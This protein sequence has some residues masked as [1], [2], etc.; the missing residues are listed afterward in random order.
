MW[1]QVRGWLGSLNIDLELNRTKLLFGVHNE[2]SLSVKNYIILTVKYYIWRTKFQ[3]NQLALRDYQHYLKDKLDDLKNACFL[4]GK[5]IIFEPW[6]V[7]YNCIER[8]CTD[9]SVAPMPTTADLQTLPTPP[10]S[11]TGPPTDLLTTSPTRQGH[12]DPTDQAQDIPD[13]HQDHTDHHQDQLDQQQVQVQLQDP[14]GQV[15]VQLEQTMDT[16]T[17]GQG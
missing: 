3:N 10:G 11:P 6:L 4:M 8:L 17:P 1:Q 5:E 7:I 14:T 9:T 13:L 16:L 15:E 2:G 12:Q